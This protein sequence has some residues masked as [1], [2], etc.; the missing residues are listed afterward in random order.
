MLW[1]ANVE[2]SP[3]T[4]RGSELRFEENP[5]PA[6]VDSAASESD[7]TEPALSRMGGASSVVT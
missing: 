4:P 2:F 1:L 5:P 7:A 6:R 3:A